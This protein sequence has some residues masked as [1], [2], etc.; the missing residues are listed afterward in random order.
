[1]NIPP[2]KRTSVARNVH[3]PSVDASCCWGMSSNCSASAD[4]ALAM[5]Q[6]LLGL[7]RV[8]VGGFVHQRDLGKIMLRRR[9]GRLPL[10]AGGFPRIRRGLFAVLQ[11]PDE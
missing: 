7:G 5:N 3:M 4:C 2:K 1:M 9:R 11:R 10:Q 8:L 6:L